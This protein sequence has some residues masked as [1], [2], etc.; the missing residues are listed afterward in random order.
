MVDGQADEELDGEFIVFDT[1]TTGLSAQNDRLTEIGAV[2]MKNGEI[3]E[4]FD[5][6]VNPERPIPP[7]I[8]MCI[9]DRLWIDST[10]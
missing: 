4:E 1:E 6:F 2:R 9:R 8:K 7:K 3:L 5:T 10:A